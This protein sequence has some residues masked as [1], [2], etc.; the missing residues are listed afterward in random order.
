ML[1]NFDDA[2]EWTENRIT[3]G[4]NVTTSNGKSIDLRCDKN[5]VYDFDPADSLYNVIHDNQQ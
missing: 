2:G 4:V 3:N 1:L 5:A